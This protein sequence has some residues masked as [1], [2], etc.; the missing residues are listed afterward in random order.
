MRILIIIPTR[1]GRK[2]LERLLSTLSSQDHPFDVSVVDSSSTDGTTE[3]AQEFGAKVHKV[4]VENFNHGGTRQMMVDLSPGYDVYVFL[5]QD[6]YLEN[7]SAIKNLIASF[8]DKKVGAAYGRQLPH[9]DASLLAQHAR[10]FNY[11]QDSRTKSFNDACELGIKTPFISNSFAAYRREALYDA[12]GF[13]Q[14]VILSEDM[15]VAAKM[16]VKGW[17]VA[18]VSDACVRHSHNYGIFEEFKRYFDTGVFHSR[19]TW[20]RGNF[21]QAGGEGL[22]YV[23]SELRYLGFRRLYLWP[24]SLLRNAFKLL[25]Y[26]AGLMESK[27]PK[28]MK[29]RWSMHWRYWEGPYA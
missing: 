23:K 1:N 28:M 29:K 22:R 11:P 9:L 25:G 12:G 18:Y 3:V 15:Y 21:G 10:R 17:E 24:S 27:L 5:T 7:E 6:A 14:H 26:K 8:D 13:P 16:L 2:E 19:E 4:A 20:V